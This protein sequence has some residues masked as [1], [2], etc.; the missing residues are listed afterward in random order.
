M[1]LLKGLIETPVARITPLAWMRIGVP[2][3]L[4]GLTMASIIYAAFFEQFAA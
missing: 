3:T 1:R 4:L 2:T